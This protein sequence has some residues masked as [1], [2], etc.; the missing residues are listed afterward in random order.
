MIDGLKGFIYDNAN[1]ISSIVFIG[2][3]NIYFNGTIYSYLGS[4]AQAYADKYG[5]KF[6]ALAANGK[7][8]GNVNGDSSL[9]SSDAAMILQHYAV[10]QSDGAGKFTEAQ[11]AVADY[12]SD[13]NIDS[14]DA[15]LILKA[16]AENQ[17]R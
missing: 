16:Y 10:F 17:S 3:E 11:L 15:A 4:T 1:T 9:D 14:S 7:L 13:S 2:E 6:S 8:L 5:Y 12:N